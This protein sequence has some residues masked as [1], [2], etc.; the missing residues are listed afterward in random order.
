MNV[1]GQ[2]CMILQNCFC[3]PLYIV[4]RSNNI[5]RLYIES[6]GCHFMAANAEPAAIS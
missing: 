2:G 6:M 1:T 3:N 4:D 5:P